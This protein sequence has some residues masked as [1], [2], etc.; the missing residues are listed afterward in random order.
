[1]LYINRRSRLIAAVTF[2]CMVILCGMLAYYIASG[3]DS[4]LEAQTGEHA[5]VDCII[6]GDPVIKPF[7][8]QYDVR[9]KNSSEKAFL[10]VKG[11]RTYGYG[12]CVRVYCKIDDINGMRNFGDFD[13]RGYY[14]NKGI[15]KILTADRVE[16][17]KGRGC[18]SLDLFLHASKSKVREV[19]Y[20]ALPGAEAALMYGIITGDRTDMDEETKDAYAKAGL[21]H[22]LSVS[23]LHVG[24]LLLMINFLLGP[25]KL[26]IRFK[27]AITAIV[28]FYYILVIGAPAPALR[29]FLMLVFTLLAKIFRRGYDLTSSISAAMLI[30]LLYKPMS[31]HDP[32][33]VISFGCMYSIAFFYEPLYKRLRRLPNVLRNPLAVSLAVWLGIT[34]VLV[35][36]FNYASVISII[37]NLAAIPLSFVIT[38]M[39]FVG[40]LV[41]CIS[42]LAALYIFSV[43]YYSLK[44][45]NL[46]T[47]TSAKLP[48]A[49][50]YIPR[51]P[52]Y[53][54]IV[55]YIAFLQFLCGTSSKYYMAYQKKFASATLLLVVLSVGIYISP[56][57][58]LKLLFID[59]GQGDSTCIV[60]PWKRVMLIDGGGTLK[61][62]GGTFD[63]G[64]DITVPALLHNGVWKIDT[65]MLSHIDDDHLEG[66]L[67]VLEVF[68]VRNLVMPETGFTSENQGKLLELCKTKNV[69]VTYLLSGDKLRL[70]SS[71]SMEIIWP[72]KGLIKG[73]ESDVNNNSLVGRLVY[74]DFSVLF[75]GDIQSEAEERISD[76]IVKVDVLKVP[77]HGSPYSSTKA[78]VNKLAPKLSVIQ[79]GKN[80]YGHPSPKAI[81]RLEQAGS[82]VY[83]LDKSGAVKLVTD[84]RRMWVR[85]VST[86]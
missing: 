2:I 26:D 42:K 17:L 7:Y 52:L 74:K 45:L 54:W 28:V 29:A 68:R 81:E 55:Y 40:V 18:G 71:I 41:G 53:L 14:K 12:S 16:T 76:R 84:G 85:T 10:R 51:L 11:L 79:V 86:P 56:S 8:T 73:T 65:V 19:I 21:S 69:P 62:T 48:F 27:S 75:T 3:R 36:Y 47:V 20:S 66:L 4:S 78:F 6:A 5:T 70:G 46:L 82:R 72:D 58:Y 37:A 39:G 24:F 64:R 33:F 57:P 13:F 38:L 61:N 49:G 43:C 77:H 50:F 60:T 31:I 44:L 34:P 22:I 15:F 83:R 67:S 63:V 32:G 59:V 1:M 23:G 35:Y 80:N 9:L 25:F 30:L